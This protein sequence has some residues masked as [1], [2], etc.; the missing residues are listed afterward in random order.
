MRM[1]I[2]NH[3]NMRRTEQNNCKRIP[4]I[5]KWRNEK[6]EKKRKLYREIIVQFIKRQSNQELDLELRAAASA[7]LLQPNGDDLIN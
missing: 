7:L 6:R 3:T 4:S 2:C 5:F 1:M